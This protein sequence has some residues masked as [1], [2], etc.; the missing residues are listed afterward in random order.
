MLI[1]MICFDKPNH[2]EVRMKA[3]P[4][5]LAWLQASG[6]PIMSAGPILQDDGETPMG[7]LLIGDFESLAA[8]RALHKQDPYVKAG[9]FERV[10]IQPTRKVLPAA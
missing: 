9:L 2:V 10:I 3:R 8:A 1:A 4:E 5:H 7:T 6:V